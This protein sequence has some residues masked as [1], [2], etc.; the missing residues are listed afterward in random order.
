MFN[1]DLDLLPRKEK[2]SFP[3]EVVEEAFRIL[4]EEDVEWEKRRKMKQPLSTQR[5]KSWQLFRIEKNDCW[6][7]DDDD[8]I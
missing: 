7:D 4:A 8:K 1:T 3:P 6:S 5:Q 2:K